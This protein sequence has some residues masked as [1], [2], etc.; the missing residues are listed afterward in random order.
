MLVAAGFSGG[1]KR[2]F[3]RQS[4]R[5]DLVGNQVRLLIVG[6][7]RLTNSAKTADDSILDRVYERDE[8]LAPLSPAEDLECAEAKCYWGMAA[9]RAPTHY[10][11]HGPLNIPQQI[12]SPTESNHIARAHKRKDHYARKSDS[13]RNDT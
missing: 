12:R 9:R 2:L 7:N 13:N 6:L 3:R 10:R 8:N 1:R 5:V 4:R 11:C